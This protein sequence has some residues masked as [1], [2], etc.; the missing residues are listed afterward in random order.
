MQIDDPWSWLVFPGELREAGEQE[1]GG[2]QDSPLAP[3]QINS[4]ITRPLTLMA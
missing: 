1:G 2:S 4:S 3:F